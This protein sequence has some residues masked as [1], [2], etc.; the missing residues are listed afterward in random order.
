[1]T[2]H[3]AT[4]AERHFRQSYLPRLWRSSAEATIDGIVSRRLPDR[5]LGRAIENAWTHETR[6]PSRMMQELIGAFRPAGLHVFRHRKAML[7]VSPVR[8][9]PFS[10]DSSSVSPSVARIL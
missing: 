8:P 10:H 4:E 9:R 3:S 5:S 6:S 2:F 7:F 1:L